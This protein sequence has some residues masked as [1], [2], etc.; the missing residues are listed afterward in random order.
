M[1]NLIT[2][3]LSCML[4]CGCTISIK[5]ISMQG[6]DQDLRDDVQPKQKH[7]C[8]DEVPFNAA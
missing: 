5:N 8:D 7:K 2:C 6:T 1:K 4:L 3:L